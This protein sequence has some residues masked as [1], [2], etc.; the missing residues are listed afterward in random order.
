M[1]S[2]SFKKVG[3]LAMD[4]ITDND[5]FEFEITKSCFS[6]ET[7]ELGGVCAKSLY[8]LIDNHSRR[9]TP[10]LLANSRME[11]YINGYYLG[12]YNVGQ[13]KHRGGVIEITAFDDMTMLDVEYPSTYIFPQQ[14]RDVYTQCLGAAGLPSEYVLNA[15]YNNGII[16]GKYNEY[17][18]AN[19]CRKLISGMAE[20]NGGFAYINDSDRLQV[21]LFS[22][23]VT[24]TFSSGDLMELEYSDDTITFTKIKTSQNNKTYEKGT[25]GGYTLVINNQYISYGLLDEHFELYLNIL[26]EYYNDFTLTPMSFTLAEPDFELKLGDRVSVY[27]E[28]E[29]RYVT[30]NISKITISGNCSM[31]VTC[32]GFAN[33]TTSSG[34][35]TPSGVGQSVQS[36][37]AEKLHTSGSAY[38]AVTRSIN[39]A[40]N[41]VDGLFLSNGTTELVICDNSGT[42]SDGNAY[43]GWHIQNKASGGFQLNTMVSDAYSQFSVVGDGMTLKM[44]DSALSV[45]MKYI[46][47]EGGIGWR[48]MHLKND[49]F[50]VYLGNG[51]FIQFTSGGFTI[52]AANNINLTLT[53]DGLEING[54]KVVLTE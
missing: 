33:G 31:T 12:S 13:P 17:I 39:R 54:K 34:S 51:A 15:L 40:G 16:S 10:G 28:E 18:Y 43:H 8:L 52:H 23:D 35:Y 2:I 21:D 36:K 50:D 4:P 27:D 11:V 53:A 30:G 24:K 26:Y 48:M 6:G 46:K 5:L 32:G 42:D 44:R 9:F 41:P 3:M 47:P 25:D 1:I 19:S 14:F 20:W 37:T 7:F 22:K 38:Y 49:L 45:E 29:M